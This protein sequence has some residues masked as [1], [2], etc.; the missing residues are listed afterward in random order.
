MW[1]QS[2]KNILVAGHRGLPALYPEN[3]LASFKGA[4]DARVDMIELDI[5]MSADGQ[6]VILHDA[7]LERTTNG[8]GLLRDKTLAQLRALDAGGWFSPE[9][10][11]EKIPLFTEFLELTKDCPN[12]LFDFELKEYPID[13]NEERAYRTTDMVIAL[14]EEYGI[15]DRLVFNAFN[16]K[17]LQYIDDKYSAKYKLHGYLPKC[18]MGSFERDPYSYLYCACVFDL[19]K[20][21]FDYL[22]SLGVDTWVGCSINDGERIQVA[23]SYGATL[24][25]CN[26]PHQVLEI[27]RTMGLHQ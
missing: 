2:E 24:I 13:G 17:L 26:N 23:A 11:G 16:A 7:S 10:A 14:A 15:G 8:T 25:T 5:R 27:L 21:N 19:Q 9:F 1:K 18:E 3:T 12:L 20:E 6:P 4:L 22:K